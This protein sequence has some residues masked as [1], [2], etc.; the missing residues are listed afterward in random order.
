MKNKNTL[1][2]AAAT[3]ALAFGASNA[4][5]K[6][7]DGVGKQGDSAHATAT[8]DTASCAHHARLSVWAANPKFDRQQPDCAQVPM[9]K[10]GTTSDAVMSR[11]KI[12][13]GNHDLQWQ[14]GYIQ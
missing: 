3:L 13:E 9:T 6:Y 12:L 10:N 2:L 5:A 1:I 14:Q 4:Q 7:D 11:G 8:G